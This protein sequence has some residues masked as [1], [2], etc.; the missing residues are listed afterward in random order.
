MN[1]LEQTVA[2]FGL[3]IIGSRSA[4]NLA[5]ATK[6]VV[7]W[8]RTP[9]SSPNEISCA[10]DAAKQ[11]DTLCFYLK[12]GVACREVFETIRPALT[13]NHV[14]INHSTIDLETTLWLNEQCEAIGC[15]FLD[16]PF[17]GSKVAAQNGELVYY[18]GGETELLEKHRKLL[19]I[20]SKE[21]G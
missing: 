16:C 12:D 19:E 1:Q 13:E 21:N 7:V 20:T 11:A 3:G 4:D 10:L 8:N 17:T 2:V 15:G 18:F 9:K 5:S 6:N 14:L